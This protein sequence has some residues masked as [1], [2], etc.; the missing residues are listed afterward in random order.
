[1]KKG[2][3]QD[4]VI[5]ARKRAGLSQQQVCDKIGIKQGSYSD[6]ESGKSSG[7]KFTAQIADC[8]RVNALWLA[9]GIGKHTDVTRYSEL[10]ADDEGAEI[11]YLIEEIAQSDEKEKEQILRVLKAFFDK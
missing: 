6:L 2:T 5:F 4:R 9:T 7:S 11:L 8:L 10:P 3:Y 1:M